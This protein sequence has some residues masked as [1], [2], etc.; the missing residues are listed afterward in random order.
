MKPNGAYAIQR[1]G[2][3]IFGTDRATSVRPV[4]PGMM[5]LIVGNTMR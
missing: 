4:T 3:E 1:L 2:V 5:N